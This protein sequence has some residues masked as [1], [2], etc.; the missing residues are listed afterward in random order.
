MERCKCGTCRTICFAS[1]DCGSGIKRYDLSAIKSGHTKSCGCSKFNNPLI[2]EDLTGKQFGRLTVI[3]RDIE[4]DKYRGSKGGNAHWLCKC[5]CGNPKL[6]S[7]SG[8]QLKTGG[9]KS[10]G[11]IVSETIAERNKICSPK[12]NKI[13]TYKDNHIETD[14]GFIRIWDEDKKNSFLI[15]NDDY[16]YISKW[17]WRKTKPRRSSKTD[18]YWVTNAKREDI[19]NGY[20]ATI[21][22]HQIIA[23]RKYGKYDKDKYM[24][25]HLTR[26]HDNNRRQNIVLK[27][28]LDNAH[29]RNK[30]YANK[31]GKTGVCYRKDIKKW[32]AY[33]TVNYKHILLGEYKLYEDAVDARIQAEK[34]YGFTCD[35]VVPE[36]DSR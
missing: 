27:S 25:D 15:D 2:M 6:S 34:Q 8:Y 35:D 12:H 33:I 30:S 23:E 29:N 1:C 3:E 9:T 31:S 14:E 4:R 24:P 5:S 22:L 21:K 36:Y 16:T 11:C 19:I 7:I 18:G 26:D 17:Y 13:Y 10:C 28:N 32:S 20:P